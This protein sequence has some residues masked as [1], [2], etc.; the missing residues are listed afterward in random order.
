M[1]NETQQYTLEEI[2][3]DFY[4]DVDMSDAER[5]LVVGEVIGMIT[6]SA[7]LR[8]LEQSDESVQNAFTTLMEQEPTEETIDNF[9]QN[10]I[11]NFEKIVF[12]EIMTFKEIGKEAEAEAEKEN[13]N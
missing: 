13:T 9:I 10:N 12:E 6:E 1:N 5:S 3:T 2:I 4:S 11:P 8:S 7:I